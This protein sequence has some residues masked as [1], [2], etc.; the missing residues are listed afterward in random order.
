MAK[1]LINLGIEANDGTGDSLRTGAFKINQ[2]FDELYAAIGNG[3][4]SIRPGEGVSVAGSLGEI[5]LTNTLPNR[6]SFNTIEVSG[7]NSITTTQLTDTLTLVA[8]ENVEITTD[9]IEKTVT[10]SVQNIEAIDLNGTF[11]GT[12]TGTV[13]GDISGDIVSTDIDTSLL[14]VSGNPA[15]SQSYYSGLM[16][17]RNSI[18]G[19]ISSLQS[20][21]N[22]YQGSLSTAQSQLAYWQSQP[23]SS[24]RTAQIS[25]L[26]SQI[27]SLSAQIS[28]VQSQISQKTAELDAV[29]D[30]IAQIYPTLS[31]PYAS[32]T[33]NTVSLILSANRHLLIPELSVGEVSY[34]NT[35][36]LLGQS[37]TTDGNGN[38]GWSSILGNLS[39]TV[40]SGSNTISTNT[41]GDYIVIEAFESAANEGDGSV[42]LIYHPQ[43]VSNS[44]QSVVTVG[45]YGVVLS[46][47]QRYINVYNQ[48]IIYNN[49]H[50]SAYPQTS[51]VPQVSTE[52][53]YSSVGSS[54]QTIKLLVFA[55]CNQEVQSSE[56]IIAKNNSTVVCSV[57]GIVY[58]GTSALCE[59]NAQ[60]NSVNN[61]IEVTATNLHPTLPAY[62]TVQGNE[63]SK[64]N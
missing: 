58:T 25:S 10:I 15:S 63:L 59:F 32:L 60:W 20:L 53:I 9:S 39:V 55:E 36:G 61:V 28:G 16:Q 37:L 40:D 33:Y 12:F 27:A 30:A 29:D 42:E 4:Y 43:D 51:T 5:T 31:T 14:K 7:Q 46:V 54:S 57:Y 11:T 34:P 45:P 13:S 64:S 35:D 41:D 50:T 21:Y 2:N 49:N 48:G 56:I 1:Q 6:G 52:I 23:P 24:E 26:N 62:F 47:D 17:N 22:G 19:Q 18:L 44:V 8:G 38:I 3:I